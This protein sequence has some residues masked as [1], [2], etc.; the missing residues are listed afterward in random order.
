MCSQRSDHDLIIE[1]ISSE[2]FPI[3]EEAYYRRVLASD[4]LFGVHATLEGSEVPDTF[5][6]QRSCCGP[7]KWSAK[8]QRL[9]L[10]VLYVTTEVWSGLE[11]GI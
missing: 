5:T 1:I 3:T 9:L 10:V 7:Y 11:L 4:F 6:E 8:G 2:Y